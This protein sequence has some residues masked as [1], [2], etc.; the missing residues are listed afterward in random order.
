MKLPDGWRQV[1]I[2]DAFHIQL[3]KMLSPNAKIGEQCP[4]V[5]P[6]ASFIGK[7]RKRACLGY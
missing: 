5:T 4:Y 7:K 3:G 6:C 1:L 2:S